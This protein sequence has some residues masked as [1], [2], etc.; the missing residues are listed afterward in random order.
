MKGRRVA[1]IMKY[2]D[3]QAVIAH[4]WTWEIEWKVD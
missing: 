4:Q 3:W 2:S 1:S